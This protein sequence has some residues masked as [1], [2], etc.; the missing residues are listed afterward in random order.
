MLAA[1]QGF[2][3]RNDNR[4]KRLMDEN[5]NEVISH[6]KSYLEYLRGMG[7]VSLPASEAKPDESSPSRVMTL[8]DVRKEL[9]DCKRCKLHRTRRTIVFGEGD[10][11]ATLMFVGEG[12]GYDED[13]QG[14]PFV[15]KAGQLLTKIIESIKLS[16]EEVYIAN[17]VKCRP[18]QNRNPEPDEIQSCNPFLMKQILVIQPKIICALGT[19]SAQTLLKTDTKIS[20]L[21]GKIFDLEG[22]K[23]IPTYHPAFLLR[24]PERKRE[25]WEDM[26][27]IA[28][29]LNNNRINE[30]E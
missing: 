27:K 29:W 26:K 30:T 22:I 17:I 24:N 21:R 4:R 7:I 10:E 19:F 3:R 15:G 28:E 11:R 2:S 9:G 13:V 8:E 16:R 1:R 20:D 25:V 12:P 14:R 6:L 23:V 18:P 5:M